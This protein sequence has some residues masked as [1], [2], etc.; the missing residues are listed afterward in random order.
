M[1]NYP[2]LYIYIF[3]HGITIERE[4][5]RGKYVL[6]GYCNLDPD[7]LNPDY[8]G[9]AGETAFGNIYIYVRTRAN[10]FIIF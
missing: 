1:L 3:Q 7:K 9:V 2:S 10:F 4:V 6:D 5:K 8:Q